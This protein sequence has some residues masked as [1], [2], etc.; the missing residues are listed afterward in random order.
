MLDDFAEL[1]T[2]VV[3][4]Q[5]VARDTRRLWRF[6]LL[7]AKADEEVRCNEWGLPHYGAEEN[8]SDCLCNRGSRP[9]TDLRVSAAWRPTEAMDYDGWVARVR[10]PLHPL[11]ESDV[12]CDR[13]SIFM[14]LMH[15][16]DC[17]GV[18]SIVYGGCWA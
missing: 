11:V 9:F 10:R 17:N 7:V 14:E 4:A 2:G 12:V 16:T 1:T 6:V 13:W 5:E 8:C 15:L 18:P 3:G